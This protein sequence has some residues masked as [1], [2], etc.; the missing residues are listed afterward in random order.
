MAGIGLSLG[1]GRTTGVIETPNQQEIPLKG[2]GRGHVLDAE[3]SQRPPL[4]R[5]VARPLSAETPAPVS[6]ATSFACLS[7]WA[8]PEGRPLH[9]D[10]QDDA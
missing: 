1:R 2:H 8:A 6:K 5:K 7:T 4:L 10:Q 9:Q 3:P